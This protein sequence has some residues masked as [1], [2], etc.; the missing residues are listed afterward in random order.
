VE[1]SEVYVLRPFN[2]EEQPKLA[3]LI[4]KAAGVL[5]QQLLRET[6]EESTFD[7]L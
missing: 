6:P 1:P 3:A 4:E 7:L 2:D 5:H